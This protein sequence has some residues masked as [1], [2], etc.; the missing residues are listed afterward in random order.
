MESSRKTP[1][2]GDDNPTI[3]R[4]I[5]SNYAWKSRFM[6]VLF[7]SMIH[8]DVEENLMKNKTI[9][10]KHAVLVLFEEQL[11]SGGVT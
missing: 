10:L 11:R 6:G 2:R 3:K 7:V 4:P 5:D 9:T 8:T 1:P